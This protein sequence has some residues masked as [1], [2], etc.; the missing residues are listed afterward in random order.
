MKKTTILGTVLSGVVLATMGTSSVLAAEVVGQTN[1]TPTTVT[2]TDNTDPANPDVD[3]LDPTDPAQKLLTLEKVPDAYSFESTLQNDTYNLTSTLTDKSIDVFNDRSAREW[4]VK[5]NVTD[6]KLTK[7]TNEFTVDSFKVNDVEVG[8]TAADGIVAKA[9]NKT[10]AEN[11][12]VIK[13][14]VTEVSI[15]FTDTAKVLKVGD[16]LNGSI[17]YQ[18]FNTPNAK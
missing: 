3:P 5:A 2:I 16:T 10:A 13:T 6:N 8:A 15:A 11:T 7:G 17:H 12:G 1:D 14:P 4:S 9:G 18:L